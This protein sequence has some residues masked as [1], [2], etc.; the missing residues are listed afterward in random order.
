MESFSN[1]AEMPVTNNEKPNTWFSS[2]ITTL[3]LTIVNSFVVELTK[4]NS[5]I[6]KADLKANPNY[7]LLFT[8]KKFEY[9]CLSNGGVFPEYD[10]DAILDLIVMIDYENTPPFI[11]Q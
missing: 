8:K 11:K 7:N 3:K 6:I 1:Y 5:A 4:S 10:R 9:Y 2:H